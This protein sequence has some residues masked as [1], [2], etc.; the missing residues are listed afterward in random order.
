MFKYPYIALDA[1]FTSNLQ[2]LEA[3][4]E[5]NIG[6]S[7][8]MVRRVIRQI[9]SL[10]YVCFPPAFSTTITLGFLNISS[11][12]ENKSQSLAG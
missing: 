6:L 10:A 1:I 9:L 4:I 8:P 5:R 7:L 3:Y 11:T 12:T 2:Y